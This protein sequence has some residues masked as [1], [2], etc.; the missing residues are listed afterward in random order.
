[1]LTLFFQIQQERIVL[2]KAIMQ[3][4]QSPARAL[5]KAAMKI[6]LG[7]L[8]LQRAN[9]HALAVLGVEEPS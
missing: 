3:L 5:P 9:R 2:T 4:R 7:L 6:L 8:R 1:M